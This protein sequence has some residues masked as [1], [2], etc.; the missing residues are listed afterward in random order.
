MAG[1]LFFGGVPTGPEVDK[2][3]EKFGAP[4]PGVISHEQIEGVIGQRRDSSRYHTIVTQWRRRLL[5]DRNLD[6]SAEL[7]V[8]VRILSE[9]ERVDVSAKDLCGAS[10]KAIKAYR[11]ASVIRSEM[12]DE[13]SRKKLDFVKHAGGQSIEAVGTAVREMSNALRAVAQMPRLR[14]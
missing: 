12:L 5:K 11:R 13:V 7:G 14:K 9:P 8:G 10:R 3:L 6:T 2:L 1:K 4:E